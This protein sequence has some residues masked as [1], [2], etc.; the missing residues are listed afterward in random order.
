VS[1]L[2]GDDGAVYEPGHSSRAARAEL[3]G[4]RERE[5]RGP[6][7]IGSGGRAS[8]A[9]LHCAALLGHVNR[10]QP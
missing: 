1:L 2:V 9:A 8:A 10:L 6:L 3:D 7:S 4:E 5:I